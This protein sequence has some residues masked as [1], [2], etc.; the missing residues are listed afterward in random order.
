MAAPCIRSSVSLRSPYNLLGR[1]KEMR[2]RRIPLLLLDQFVADQQMAA[3]Q[4]D[5]RGE[6]KLGRQIGKPFRFA[7]FT[8]ILL[9]VLGV[10]RQHQSIGAKARRRRA[11]NH[12]IGNTNA[13]ERPGGE[14]PQNAARRGRPDRH[15]RTDAE[16]NFV[17]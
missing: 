5:P 9:A 4:R 8:G 16:P 15:E 14:R 7:P 2:Q 13:G 3:Q 17:P 10:L 11:G 6:G 1:M 12:P